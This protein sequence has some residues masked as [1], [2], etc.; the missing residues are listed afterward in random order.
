MSFKKLI[1]ICLC[2]TISLL[3]G[4][5]SSSYVASFGAKSLHGSVLNDEPQQSIEMAIKDSDRK[6]SGFL[7]AHG[8]FFPYSNLIH[9]Q[10]GERVGTLEF[11]YDD[12]VWLSDSKGYL[13]TELNSKP[14]RFEVIKSGAR[15]QFIHD[16]RAWHGYPAQSLMLFTIPADIIFSVAVVPAMIIATPFIDEESSNPPQS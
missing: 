8:H 13:L 16:Y 9:E 7:F 5:V 1:S 10:D 12:I 15:L 4:C 11:G 6:V 2:C 3:S 14:I